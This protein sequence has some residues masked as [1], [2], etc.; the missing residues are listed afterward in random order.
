M[1]AEHQDGSPG[2]SDFI[3]LWIF[4]NT[5]YLGEKLGIRKIIPWMA[6]MARTECVAILTDSVSI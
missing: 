6:F 5:F 3:G 1:F 4:C 2:D